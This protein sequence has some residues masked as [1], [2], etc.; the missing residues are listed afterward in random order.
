MTDKTMTRRRF[1]ICS[2]GIAALGVGC[3]SSLSP[4]LEQCAMKSGLPQRTLGNTGVQVS[5]LA[6]GCGSVFLKGYPSDDKAQEVLEWA[7]NS[8]INY[9]DTAHNYGNG[10]SER[11]LG[12][13]IKGR[14]EKVFLVTKIE[15]RDSNNFMRQFELS[16]KRLQTDRVDLLHIHG[17]HNFEDLSKIGAHGGVYDCLVKLKNQKAAK[18]IGFSCHTDGEVA[19]KAIEQLDFDCCML[20]LNAANIGEFEKKALPAALNKKMGI[21]AMKAT[22]QGKLLEEAPGGRLESLLHYVWSLPVSS[23]VLGMPKMEM[24]KQ[25]VELAKNIMLMGETEIITLRDRL[26]SYRPYLEKFFRHHSD[27]IAT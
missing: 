11:R 14:R 2:T 21:L 18:L 10:E 27:L 4:L 16:L 15:S 9:F 6:F 23:I 24:A 1:L 3:S 5:L 7:L 13:F 22:A 8:G 25:N 20:Q 17:L 26:S 12:L 19:E